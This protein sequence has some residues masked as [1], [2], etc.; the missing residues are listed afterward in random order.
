MITPPSPSRKH[1]HDGHT[2]SGAWGTPGLRAT[3]D[4]MY[5]AALPAIATLTMAEI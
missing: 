5:I 1:A 4:R 3:A 2:G